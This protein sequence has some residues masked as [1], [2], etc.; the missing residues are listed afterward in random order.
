MIKRIIAVWILGCGIWH[1][2]SVAA[3]APTNGATATA[4]ASAGQAKTIWSSLGLTPEK[5][6]A[7]KAKLCNSGITKMVQ[8]MLAPVRL[9]TGGGLIGPCC[10]P[11]PSPADLAKMTPEN[12]PA[13]ESAAA[14]IKA[15]EAGAKAR[16]AAVKYLAT[17]DC[18][19]WPEAEMALIAALRGD[20]NECVRLEAAMALGTGCCCTKKTVEA[21]T[22]VVTASDKDGNPSET[23]ERVKMAALVSLQQC[24]ARVPVGM[25]EPPELPPPSLA[26][27]TP[28]PGL[29]QQAT[30][31]LRAAPKPAADDPL[32][33]A[34]KIFAQTAGASSTQQ[35]FPTG[36][37]T[38]FNILA[39]ASSAGHAEA[40]TAGAAN[41]GAATSQPSPP[42]AQAQTPR[43]N[44]MQ[45][46]TLRPLDLA[47][48][49][50]VPR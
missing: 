13:S 22:L 31:T 48:I 18:H 45:A 20:K 3:Q 30:F 44:A 39:H 50:P 23:S 47:P 41:A 37:R 34:R 4:Q 42:A 46:Q 24:V 25:P 28:P 21:L 12:T 6:A 26:P 17:V 49:G 14:K 8:G 19:Y 9:A 40:A 36:S 10:P 27:E 5:Y 29:L 15:D 43:P 33:I 16:R 11:F 38:L 1:V 32:V 35:T 7:C 2:G